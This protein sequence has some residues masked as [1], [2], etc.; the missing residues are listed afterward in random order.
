MKF[1]S[2]LAT[3]RAFSFPHFAVMCFSFG[4]LKLLSREENPFKLH[5]L[6]FLFVFTC[7]RIH[8]S[9]FFFFLSWI[10]FGWI[11]ICLVCEQKSIKHVAKLW[12]RHTTASALLLHVDA[13][14]HWHCLKENKLANNIFWGVLRKKLILSSGLLWYKV[15]CRSKQM[16]FFLDESQNYFAQLRR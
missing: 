8:K 11:L 15:W 4:T 2:F 16:W 13:A 6:G 5:L 7:H 14:L 10:F 9:L 3:H 12:K 1:N